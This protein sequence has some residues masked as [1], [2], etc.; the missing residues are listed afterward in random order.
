MFVLPLE[1]DEMSPMARL[2]GSI[3]AI[4]LRLF[5]Q[6]GKHHMERYLKV[7]GD[8]RSTA[9]RSTVYVLDEGVIDSKKCFSL[10]KYRPTSS[11]WITP[12]G[13]KVAA[14]ACGHVFVAETKVME[15]RMMYRF[16][17]ANLED[18][19]PGEW[20][21]NLQIAFAHFDS[22]FS[23]RNRLTLLKLSKETILGVHS[24]RI[25]QMIRAAW[26]QL[27]LRM[28]TQQ[29]A[30]AR[31]LEVVSGQRLRDRNAVRHGQMLPGLL[32]PKEV[33]SVLVQVHYPKLVS[34]KHLGEV[35]YLLEA[36]QGVRMS[37]LLHFLRLIET[38]AVEFLHN[39]NQLQVYWSRVAATASLDSLQFRAIVFVFWKCTERCPTFVQLAGM[40]P[41]QFHELIIGLPFAAQC[42]ES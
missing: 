26:E 23:E 6:V 25:Q 11:V 24:T 27:K 39:V 28:N 34:M 35:L 13:W 22:R 2:D 30:L 20:N 12:N 16:S 15:E 29:L 38:S 36:G 31:S 9:A 3:R 32:T 21:L 37:H 33:A 4:L 5:A 42:A 40:N 41:E 10:A 1:Y 7:V 8:T 14:V 18:T 19:V 17:L